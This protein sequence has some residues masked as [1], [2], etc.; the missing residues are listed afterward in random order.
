MVYFLCVNKHRGCLTRKLFGYDEWTKP[1]VSGMIEIPNG[2]F[3]CRQ[4]YEDMVEVG[5]AA[6]LWPP[7]RL[8]RAGASSTSYGSTEVRAKTLADPTE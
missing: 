2:R 4:C 7:R 1:E 8:R 5:L 3:A 6:D